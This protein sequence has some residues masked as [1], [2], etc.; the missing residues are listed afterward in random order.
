MSAYRKFLKVISIISLVLS[1][2]MVVLCGVGMATVL[3]NPDVALDTI[4]QYPIPGVDNM[5]TYFMVVG[6]FVVGLVYFVWEAFVAVM[7]IRGA[8]NPKKMGFVTTIAGIT[9][10][11]T[12]VFFVVNIATSGFSF[13]NDFSELLQAVIDILF[14]Y[15]CLQIRKEG[16]D[17]L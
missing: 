4:K 6:A 14:F 3:S 1:V 16:K 2:I 10:V 7:G 15:I 13:Q 8:N 17:Q 9:A 5:D 11:L 12:V